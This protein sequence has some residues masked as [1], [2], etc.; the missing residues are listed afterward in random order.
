M[1]YQYENAIPELEKALEIFDKWGS[2]PLWDANYAL[3]GE[4]YHKTGNFKKEKKLYRKAIR[5]FPESRS[6]VYRQSVLSFTEG[7]TIKANK[8]IEKYVALCREQSLSEADIQTSLAYIFTEVNIPGKA[9]AYF[10]QAFSLEP[11]NISRIDTL[12]YFLIDKD[13]DLTEGMDLIE[14]SLVL[15]PENYNCLHIKGW[16]LYKQG[17]YKIALELL[18]KSWALRMEKAIYD[19]EASMHLEAAK[20]AVAGQIN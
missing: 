16:G 6:L 1:L 3:L 19:H 14:K 2:K 5:D 15:N 12:A 10:R 7:D 17:K 18:Q 11:Q 8:F 9:E 20:K 4:A 13:R